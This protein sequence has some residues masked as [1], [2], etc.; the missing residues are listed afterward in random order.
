MARS[1]RER[2]LR[3]DSSLWPP[4]GFG[5]AVNSHCCSLVCFI[6]RVCVG[7]LHY[8]SCMAHSWQ[9]KLCLC[10]EVGGEHIRIVGY[11]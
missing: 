7:L 5:V 3:M 4:I 8:D 2:P 6:A 1:Q 10:V 11:A 9:K